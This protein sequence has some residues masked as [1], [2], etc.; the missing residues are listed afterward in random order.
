MFKPSGLLA[1]ALCDLEACEKDPRYKVDF[2]VWHHPA[3]Q[4]EICHV[5]LAGAYIAKTLKVVWMASLSPEDFSNP[6][7]NRLYALDEFSRGRVVF[8]LG[9]LGQQIPEYIPRFLTIQD[10][11]DLFCLVHML[12]KYDL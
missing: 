2:G 1:Q 10:T 7:R 9:V 12:R 8:G 3:F 6:E 5:G 11:V 4:E